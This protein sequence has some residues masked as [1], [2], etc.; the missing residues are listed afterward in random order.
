MNRAAAF[1]VA[2]VVVAAVSACAEVLPIAPQPA[3][4]EASDEI[5]LLV[6]RSP[7]SRHA[8][9]HPIEV[10]AEIV[11][12]GPK[13]RETMFHAS[14]PV[15]WQLV[16]LD[17]PAEMGGGMDLPCLTTEIEPGR[18]IR[19]P[20]EKAGVVEDAGPFDR[21]WFEQPA[22]TLPQ[23]RWRVIAQLMVALGDCG[24]ERHDLEANIDLVV[25]P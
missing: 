21:A 11:Y 10:A 19:L 17:G 12:Q 9:G 3:V 14:S 6:V 24:G 20:F 18:V 7:S 2:M 25:T 22:L 4:G 15:G 8:A 23:G 16:Q 5:F 13:N 1:A